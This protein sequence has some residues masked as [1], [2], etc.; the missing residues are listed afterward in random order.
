MKKIAFCFLIYDI[1][2]LEEYWK[3]FFDKID[4]NK[5]NIYIHYKYDAKL[6]F[7]NDYKLKNCIKTDYNDM[8]SL[9]K[10]FN[11]I[12]EEALKDE[13][14]S[15]FVLLSGSCIP[16]KSFDYIYNYLDTNYSYFNICPQ[17]QCFP[18]A[19][20]AINFI[21]K[22]FIQ[23]AATWCILNRKHTD[24]LIRDKR[25]ID[26]FN[27]CYGADEH[28][29]ISALFYN[30]LENELKLTDNIALNATTFTNWEGMDYK[31][32]SINGL[33]NYEYISDVELKGILMSKSL[34]ARKFNRSCF[35]YLNNSNY[36]DVINS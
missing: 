10:A 25:Y 24:L 16:M 22:K 2:N 4:K 31:Y 33:K 14:N 11:V 27:N 28:A 9:T 21:D 36:L 15:H 12:F 7:F 5:Y 13:N 19:N 17:E 26:W 3:V 6:L 8:I 34:F 20:N 1:I 32:P 29:Y 35:N 23:K 18:R 30:N